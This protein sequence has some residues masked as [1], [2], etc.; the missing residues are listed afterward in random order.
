MILT[1]AIRG[2][3]CAA[4]LPQVLSDDEC[5]QIQ[6]R[7]KQLAFVPQD[8]CG[9]KWGAEGFSLQRCLGHGRGFV[10][11]KVWPRLSAQMDLVR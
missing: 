9:G 8:I 5:D 2:C 4:Q 10:L 7:A 1:A 3:G 11:F 6:R